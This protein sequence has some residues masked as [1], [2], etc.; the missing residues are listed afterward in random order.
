MKC[1]K[2]YSELIQLKTVV[3]GFGCRECRKIY[4]YPIDF[5]E[6][7]KY[8]IKPQ[9]VS[10]SKNNIEIPKKEVE[11]TEK[12]MVKQIEAQ[13]LIESGYRKS[14]NDLES[15]DEESDYTPGFGED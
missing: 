3:N 2:C 7:K 12:S 5:P 11:Q 8:T 1:P 14:S 9:E 10:P 4:Y 13:L 15:Y 6:T